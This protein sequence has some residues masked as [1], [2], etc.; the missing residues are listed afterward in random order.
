MRLKNWTIWFL[1]S[2]IIVL[3][4]LSTNLIKDSLH[5]ICNSLSLDQ[6]LIILVDKW[7]YN[8][9][10]FIA[11]AILTF[12]FMNALDQKSKWVAPLIVMAFGGS[13]ELLQSVIPT[14][15]SSIEDFSWNLAG[16][17]VG[18]AIWIICRGSK[19]AP[20]IVSGESK[21]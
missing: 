5:T 14:R 17:V 21:N 16:I 10:H 20:S 7:I 13:V 6:T 19:F 12:H 2:G 18:T 9:G 8:V 11:Y 1:V 4:C 3:S 15:Q